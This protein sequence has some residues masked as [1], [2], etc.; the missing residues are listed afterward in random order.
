LRTA[1]GVLW[2]VLGGQDLLDLVQARALRGMGQAAFHALVAGCAVGE[3]RIVF[4]LVPGVVIVVD[5]GMVG[6]PDNA[7]PAGRLERDDLVGRAFQ[8][9]D[10]GRPADDVVLPRGVADGLQKVHCLLHSS[11]LQDPPDDAGHRQPIAAAAQRQQ[12]VAADADGAVIQAVESDQP[13]R[14]QD[15]RLQIG[16]G[17]LDVQEDLETVPE[18]LDVHVLGHVG[19]L[20]SVRGEAQAAAVPGKK[21]VLVAPHLVQELEGQYRLPGH[22]RRGGDSPHLV[23]QVGSPAPDSR[24]KVGPAE[25]AGDGLVGVQPIHVGQFALPPADHLVDLAAEGLA[26]GQATLVRGPLE[27]QGWGYFPMT[28]GCA[29]CRW[30]H[31]F[32]SCCQGCRCPSRAR[33]AAE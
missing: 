30:R 27:E 13:G 20:G 3:K 8:V 16:S 10:L 19:R 1:D 24:D 7:A 31:H 26:V 11:L 15:E 17:V 14:A 21:D 28:S 32:P 22:V 5:Q 29:A 33:N 2:R 12:G 6:V 4:G 25:K 23:Q 9:N 18:R